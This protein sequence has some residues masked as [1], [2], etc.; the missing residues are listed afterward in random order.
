MLWIFTMIDGRIENMKNEF[1]R[2]NI[3]FKIPIEVAQMM[4]KLSLEISQKEETFFVLDSFHYYPHMTIYSQE[5]PVS[6]IERVLENMEKLSKN[7]SPLRFI[8]TE[9]ETICGYIGMGAKY[10]PE[11]RSIHET[12]VKEINSLRK[13]HL[14]EKYITAIHEQIPEEKMKNIQEYGHPDVLNL[15]KPHITITRLKDEGK[16]ERIISDIQWEIEDFTIDTIGIFKTGEHGTCVGL[17]EE[18]KLK[19]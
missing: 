9:I 19:S 15:Y 5:Y 13:S 11:L 18:F 6:S 14:R 4:A 16:T 8:A 3:A 7:F 12:I 17:I 1:S 10:S 2:I